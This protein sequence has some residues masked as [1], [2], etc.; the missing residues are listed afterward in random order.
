MIPG[1]IDDG[2]SKDGVIK[3]ALAKKLFGGPF[4]FV[5][6]GDGVGTRAECAHVN[7]TPDTGTLGGSHD[8]LSA[9]S[10]NVL[11]SVF[12]NLADDANEMDDGI[13]AQQTSFQ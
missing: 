1:T 9:A 12:A 11:K 13:D 5:I 7:E 3:S 8:I 4:G 10:M 2:W 6:T